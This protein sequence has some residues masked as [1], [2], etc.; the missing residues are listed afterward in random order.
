MCIRD[1]IMLDKSNFRLENKLRRLFEAAICANVMISDVNYHVMLDDTS[2]IKFIYD[3][4]L[5][6]GEKLFQVE[7]EKMRGTI[8]ICFPCSIKGLGIMCVSS[9][10]RP[11]D[12]TW[13]RYLHYNSNACAAEEY[14][15]LSK[16]IPPFQISPGV[17]YES[18]FSGA[19]KRNVIL[20]FT[21]NA[22]QQKKVSLNKMTLDVIKEGN[23]HDES[24]LG[25]SLNLGQ[26]NWVVRND[27]KISIN[28]LHCEAALCN[29]SPLLELIENEGNLLLKTSFAEVRKQLEKARITFAKK[30]TR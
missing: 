28:H 5:R 6:L 18:V 9:H 10:F 12:S 7:K 29:A 1:S 19:N 14:S 26:I 25:Q 2:V 24:N 30:S 4:L 20:S 13:D 3:I 21:E 27:E 8:L 16:V 15:Q 17:V 11:E 22:I 23:I